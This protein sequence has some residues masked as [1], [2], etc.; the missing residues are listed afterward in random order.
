M[1]NFIQAKVRPTS[2]RYMGNVQRSTRASVEAP[3]HPGNSSLSP[4]STP[5]TITQHEQTPCSHLMSHTHPITASSSSNFQLIINNALDTYKKRT[6]KDLRTHPLAV[7]LQSCD[8]PGAILAVLRP[9]VQGLDQSRNTDERWT[10][11]LDPTVNVLYT[12]SNIIGASVGLVC[13]R[14][15]TFLRSTFSCLR[16]R[17]SH[18]R[19]PFLPESEYSFQCVYPC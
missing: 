4:C 14:T 1:E 16:G 12:F 18:L 10:K 6:R 11:W 9:Q 17:Y 5:P 3:C 13:F 19:A 7:Q 15:F 2:G 8:S